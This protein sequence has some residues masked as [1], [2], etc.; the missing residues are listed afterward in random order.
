M[1]HFKSFVIAIAAMMGMAAPAAAQL[2]VTVV[3]EE[4]VPM[5]IAVPDFDSS[6]T[7]AAEIAAQLSEVLRKFA[8]RQVKLEEP[9]ALRQHPWLYPHFVTEEN[10]LLLSIHAL[11]IEAPGLR[12]VVDTCIGN[13]KPRGLSGGKPLATNFLQAFEATGWSR[14]SVDA[15]ICTHMHVDHAGWNTRLLDGRWVLVPPKVVGSPPP[16]PRS[17][18]VRRRP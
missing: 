2:R 7:G 5:R 17:A 15:V 16:R 10:E 6:G 3:G 9:E 14:D 8:V 4:Y 11:L 18:P 13:D 1:R 12:L